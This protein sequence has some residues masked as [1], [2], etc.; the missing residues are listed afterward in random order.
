MLEDRYGNA[1]STHSATARDHYVVGVD[2]FL[3][4][5]PDAEAPLTAAI[6]EDPD[7]CLGHLALARV[8]HACGRVEHARA[9]LATAR[10]AATTLTAR[11]AGQLQALGALIDGNAAEAYRAI[12]AHVIDHPR[13]AIA[14]QPCAGVF[15][16]IGFSGQP[17]REA[18]CLAFMTS[19]APH[20]GDDWWFLAS[21]AFAQ[22]EA[23]QLGPAEVS[24]EASLGQRPRNANAAHYRSH[25]YY[26]N[27]ESAEGYAYIDGWRKGYDRSGALHCHISWHVALWAMEQGD[28]DKMWH[29]LD[30]D[31][32]PGAAWGPALNIMT[33]M[34]ALLY[35][36]ELAGVTVP[37]KYWVA[38]SDYARASFPAPGIAFADVHA[39][40]AH[41]LAGRSESLAKIVRDANGPARE[42]VV[43]LAEAF[44]AI[45]R[46]D[47]SAAVAH[48]TVALNDHAR[49]GGSRAQRDLINLAM[50]SSLLR[51]GR[52]D[53]A[54]RFLIM[55][56]PILRN[57]LDLAGLT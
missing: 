23:G 52:R 33:D 57:R 46:T 21:L 55:Q 44:G 30:T 45:V 26:E 24:I 1:L 18:E 49:I 28:V 6:A 13:D 37:Q 7:F 38:V 22:M 11:E 2:R 5:E 40:L 42:F 51:L 31:I 35:R 8:H 54:R 39:A 56:R 43:A 50:A 47:W 36:A 25:L 48:L 34:A 10:A 29:V 12:R 17:G 19:L 3:A 27:G 53:E 4:A 15:G 32:A 41:A 9:S 20:Y 16:L 14:A